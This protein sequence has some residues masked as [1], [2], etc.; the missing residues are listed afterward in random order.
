MYCRHCGK[1]LGDWAMVCGACGCRVG[2][3]S[4]YCDTCG[5]PVA[6]DQK[7]CGACGN[8]LE[9]LSMRAK[10]VGSKNRVTAGLLAVFLG[11][12]GAHSFYLGYKKKAIM[13]IIVTLCTLGLGGIWGLVEG[14]MLFCNAEEK[15]AEEKNLQD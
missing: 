13:Q 14:I 15:D 4:R 6:G 8:S 10:T 5:A 1:E 11:G 9:K 12:F 2:D 3:G 7:T